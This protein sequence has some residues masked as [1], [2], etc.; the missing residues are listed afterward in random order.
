MAEEEIQFEHWLL[1]CI[2]WFVLFI[3][4]FSNG[5]NVRLS[6]QQEEFNIITKAQLSKALSMACSLRKIEC[7]YIFFDHF[8]V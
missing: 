8:C 1:T 6:I 2:I 5:K 3:M 4:E 7:A